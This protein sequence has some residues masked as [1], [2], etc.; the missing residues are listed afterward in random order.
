LLHFP[1]LSFASEAFINQDVCFRFTFLFS[2]SKARQQAVA[3]EQQAKN[4]IQASLDI[5]ALGNRSIQS[6][7]QPLKQIIASSSPQEGLQLASVGRQWPQQPPQHPQPGSTGP[8]SS[9]PSLPPPISNNDQTIVST[10]ALRPQNNLIASETHCP[11]GCRLRR[12]FQHTFFLSPMSQPTIKTVPDYFNWHKPDADAMLRYAMC[13]NFIPWMMALL[14]HNGRP[15][16]VDHKSFVYFSYPLFVLIFTLLIQFS[17]LFSLSLCCSSSSSI[18]LSF[19]SK[20]NNWRIELLE[21]FEY[22]ALFHSPLL[23]LTDKE[24]IGKMKQIKREQRSHLFGPTAH[25]SLM[26][27]MVQYRDDHVQQPPRKV[28]CSIRTIQTTAPL[29][30]EFNTDLAQAVIEEMNTLIAPKLGLVQPPPPQPI[31][32]AEQQ[33]PPPPPPA[34]LSAFP[35][36]VE[37]DD[38][39]QCA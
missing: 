20:E 29:G 35:S 17:A 26:E 39:M 9:Y 22:V 8:T 3:K 2:D 15:P 36:A 21:V 23:F 12:R 25:G 19:D 37:L 28:F 7:R 1:L 33:A 14:P 18:Q 24:R 16:I 13:W 27:M 32:Q 31:P 11:N 6:N 4:A 5:Q 34:A 30:W 38:S 10:T